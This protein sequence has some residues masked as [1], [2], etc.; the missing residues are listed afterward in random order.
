MKG[1]GAGEEFLAPVPTSAEVARWT[2]ETST[3]DVF[4]NFVVCLYVKFSTQIQL[5][6][7]FF[8]SCSTFSILSLTSLCLAN[9][10]I[11]DQRIRSLMSMFHLLIKQLIIQIW[12]YYNYL[13]L[14]TLNN[15]STSSFFFQFSDLSK[16]QELDLSKTQIGDEGIASLSGKYLRCVF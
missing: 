4:S 5:A 11:T 9:T 13:I 14:E 16:L 2:D 10:K 1:A 8:S 3:S 12:N 15:N 6:I 7:L